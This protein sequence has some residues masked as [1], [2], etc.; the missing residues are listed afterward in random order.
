M[1][2]SATE[3]LVA[4]LARCALEP[5]PGRARRLAQQYAEAFNDACVEAWGARLAAGAAILDEAERFLDEA[6][7]ASDP[8]ERQHLT[9]LAD[10]LITAATAGP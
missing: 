4:L 7:V 10:V 5:D 3:R 9:R 8:G 2:E 1:S 6:A